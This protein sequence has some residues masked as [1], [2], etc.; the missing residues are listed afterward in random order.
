MLQ[1]FGKNKLYFV[2]V[3]TGRCGSVSFANLLSSVGIPCSHERIFGNQGINLSSKKN[4]EVSGFHNDFILAESSYMAVPYLDNKI[5]KDALII[6]VVRDPIKV[7]LSFHNKLQY[8][9][10]QSNAWEKFILYHLP[11]ISNYSN[12]LTRSICYVVRWNEWIEKQASERR[13]I[14]IRLEYDVDKLLDYLQIPFHPK[15]KL[16]NS[17]EDW[18]Q[19]RKPLNATKEDILN[20]ELGE[21]VR[22]LSYRYG[23][24][25]I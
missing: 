6:H 10:H 25:E 18:K 14:R 2:I 21:E 23:Y 1:P 17:Y 3:G 22:R 13:Y 7:I 20:S 12:P 9:R 11:E 5:L 16:L 8:F 19:K 4:S 24:N 15:L